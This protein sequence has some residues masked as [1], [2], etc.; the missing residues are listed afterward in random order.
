MADPGW[1]WHD[2]FTVDFDIIFDQAALDQL[3]RSVEGPVGKFI[4]R[5]SIEVET[6]AKRIVPVDTGRLRTSIG[7]LIGKDD[8]EIQGA[9]GSGVEY[10]PDVEFGTRRQRAQPYL[11]PALGTIASKYGG[12]LKGQP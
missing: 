9:V 5:A 11:R 3:F 10:A 1:D 6:E 7:H 2:E 8:G 4:A 12:Q